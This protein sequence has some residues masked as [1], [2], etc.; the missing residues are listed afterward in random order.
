M[1]QRG[2]LAPAHH[3]GHAR[4]GNA[5]GL[6]AVEKRLVFRNIVGDGHAAV[7]LGRIQRIGFARDNRPHR[8]QRPQ[9]DAAPVAGRVGGRHPRPEKALRAQKRRHLLHRFL[10]EGRVVDD[11]RFAQAHDGVAL[12]EGQLLA[13]HLALAL[14]EQFAQLG[15]VGANGFYFGGVS[16]FDF[17]QLAFDAYRIVKLE[18]QVVDG[19][20][21]WQLGVCLLLGQRGEAFFVG[22]LNALDFNAA[23]QALVG[24]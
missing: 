3:G 24:P 6:E 20:L 9:H 18:A 15:R 16:C 21:G 5:G 17:A 7:L 2:R 10:G 23:E 11:R 13:L 1:Q 12:V 4:I 14:V 22:L 8:L 19:Q